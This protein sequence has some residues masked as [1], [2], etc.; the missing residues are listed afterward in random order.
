MEYTYK[1]ATFN[2]NSISTITRIRMLQ[3]FIYKHD[4]DVILLQE[5]TDITISNI[6][7]YTAYINIGSEGRGTAILAKN[8]YNIANIQSIPTGRG[9]SAHVNGIKIVNIYAPSG[10]EKKREQDDFYNSDAARLLIHP[11]P[12][13]IL[14]RDFNCVLANSDCTG[15]S[16]ISRALV[17]L[18][19]GRT[20]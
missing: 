14:A 5:V 8:C 16:N 10:S 6:Q 1:I 12:N 20:H 11:N 19:K 2:I 18:I 13:M 4:L 3:D 9:I 17:N 15:S 7:R